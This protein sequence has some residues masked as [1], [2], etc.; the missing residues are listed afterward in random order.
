MK[1]LK[2]RI[3]IPEATVPYTKTGMY[4]QHDQYLSSF[5]RRVY[6]QFGVEH[7]TYLPFEVE[8]RL[9]LWI[10]KKDRNGNEIYEGDILRHMDSKD[11]YQVVEY[12]NRY[13][14]FW[15]KSMW[16]DNFGKPDWKFDYMDYD[17]T[18]VW[19]E[20]EVVGNI[21]MNKELLEKK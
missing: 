2:C 19:E 16:I 10:G 6:N 9:M 14:H 17:R 5:L 20:H 12:D 13:C 4:Y 3:W 18:P 15:V 7:P 11:E 8:D 21:W 1:N